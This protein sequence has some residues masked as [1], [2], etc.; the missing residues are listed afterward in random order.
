VAEI[1]D[2]GELGTLEVEPVSTRVFTGDLAHFSAR[3][4]FEDGQVEVITGEAEWSL[5]GDPLG[6]FKAP[7][8]V[9]AETV[10]S[11][12]VVARVGDQEARGSIEVVA[13]DADVVGL[14]LEPTALSIPEGLAVPIRATAL[15]SNGQA[16]DVSALANWQSDDGAVAAPEVVANGIQVRGVAPGTTTLRA[17][18]GGQQTE[19]SVL[20]EATL[21]LALELFPAE[22]F[23]PAGT[24]IPLA[25]IGRFENG[26][27]FEM[28]QMVTWTTD[29]AAVA[30][31]S[32]EAGTKGQLNGIAEGTT[33]VRATDAASG[34]SAQGSALITAADVLSVQVTPALIATAAGTQVRLEASAVLTGDLTLD[35]THLADWTVAGTDVAYLTGGDTTPLWLAG[36]AP[37]STSLTCFYGGQ[38]AVVPVTITGALL[39]SVEIIPATFTMPAGTSQDFF[40]VGTYSDGTRADLTPRATWST[41]APQVALVAATPPGQ[42]RALTPGQASITALFEGF[43]GVAALTVSDADVVGLKILPALVTLPAGEPTQFEAYGIYSDDTQRPLTDQATW[44][45]SDES[46][47][48]VSNGVGQQGLAEGVSEGTATLTATLGTLS[49]TAAFVVVDAYVESILVVPFVAVMTPGHIQQGDAWASYSNGSTLKV[50]GDAVWQTTDAAVVQV[51]NAT[52]SK[53]RLQAVG[54]G[55]ATVAANFGGASGTGTIYVSEEE[56]T[57]LFIWPPQVFLAPGV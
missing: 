53:G 29:D 35:I 49:D 20:V 28:T 33:T 7:G 37:G 31:V 47:A 55:Q 54:A 32:N 43:E 17:D 16:L 56:L 46:L 8:V 39:A 21:L 24:Q 12:E 38:S 18:F 2:A 34:L 41:T 30:S 11:A 50:T 22:P 48:I 19:A 51:S 14:S 36:V 57:T 52:E 26:E 27:I 15:Y 25:A 5:D 1:A 23:L 6:A 10:G 3:R 13:R 45:S 9:F 44:T 4:V 42:V 40:F